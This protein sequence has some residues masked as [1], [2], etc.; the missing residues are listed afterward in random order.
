VRRNHT[1]RGSGNRAQQA[2]DGAHT[3]SS[4]STHAEFLQRYRSATLLTGALFAS[5]LITGTV[6]GRLTDRMLDRVGFAPLDLWELDV[7]RVFTSALVTHGGLVFA[8]AVIM[9][10]LSV[11]WVERQ[12]GSGWAMGTFWGVHV[13]TLLAMAIVVPLLE[14]GSAPSLGETLSTLRDVGPSAGYVGCLGF[15]LATIP[16]RLVRWLAAAAVMTWLLADLGGWLSVA[17]PLE[18]SADFA[19]LIAFPTG[20]A[21]EF[22]ARARPLHQHRPTA[23]EG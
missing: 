16:R 23:T 18:L 10:G 4:Q 1:P 11:G 7:L 15:A 14:G 19:H 17:G 6:L 12:A 2:R 13:L 21:L 5:A 3:L 22:V 9:T 8:G 20:W